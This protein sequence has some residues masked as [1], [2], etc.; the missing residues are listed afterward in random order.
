[1]S[2]TQIDAGLSRYYTTKRVKYFDEQGIGKF[3]EWCEVN[4]YD[5]DGVQAELDQDP[6]ECC[7][8]EFDEDFPTKKKG[9]ERT[10]LIFDVIKNA[11][12]NP[13]F[14]FTKFFVTSVVKM[15]EKFAFNKADIVKTINGLY[16]KSYD[17]YS[18]PDKDQ[19]IIHTE[20]DMN[21]II[22]HLYDYFN[23]KNKTIEASNTDPQYIP[24]FPSKNALS[25]HNYRLTAVIT[26]YYR[27][28][29]ITDYNNYKTTTE[30]IIGY[31]PFENPD[32]FI[33]EIYPAKKNKK[34][35][36]MLIKDSNN[37]FFS[38][39][40][41]QYL[42]AARYYRKIHTDISAETWSKNCKDANIVGRSDVLRLNVL[43][44]VK[45]DSSHSDIT[46]SIF[47]KGDIIL[48]IDG[49]LEIC[50]GARIKSKNGNIILNVK[51]NICLQTAA[52]IVTEGHGRIYIK[53]NNMI[54]NDKSFIETYDFGDKYNKIN[55]ITLN[56]QLNKNNKRTIYGDL[57]I[58]IKNK[59]SVKRGGCTIK[60]GDVRIK[61]G[62]FDIKRMKCI[63]GLRN[64]VNIQCEQFKAPVVLIQ[65]N[66]NARSKTMIKCN[67]LHIVV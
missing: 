7:L 55:H 44:D 40:D 64:N 56:Y 59:L 42:C 29:N 31:I 26:S 1:M 47:N 22:Q 38:E 48:N 13:E 43:R 19:I 20:K 17:K 11:S 2:T 52:K 21:K 60:S 4:G 8:V 61:C 3:K 23:I 50:A 14:G 63:L 65:K 45:I 16:D 57:Y 54:M 10:N 66:I 32:K 51:G 30:T 67:K 25:M 35:Y 27:L 58:E 6:S 36:K 41:L 34:N 62:V 53:C 12:I 24:T 18:I 49:N 33:E 9:D 39:L 5:T 37:H 46:G 28:V 15:F